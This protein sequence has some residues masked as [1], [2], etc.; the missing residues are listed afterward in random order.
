MEETQERRNSSWRLEKRSRYNLP[1]ALLV[2][3]RDATGGVECFAGPAVPDMGGFQTFPE[4]LGN[5]SLEEKKFAVVFVTAR[6]AMDFLGFTD[7]V[8][9]LR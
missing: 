3:E 4:F 1:L 9:F 5:A 7:C 6:D 8:V 2:A